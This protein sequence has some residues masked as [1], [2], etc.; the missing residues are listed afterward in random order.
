M[1]FGSR[2][3]TGRNHDDEAIFGHGRTGGPNQPRYPTRSLVF[4]R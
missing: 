3:G 2:S 1:F 4:E